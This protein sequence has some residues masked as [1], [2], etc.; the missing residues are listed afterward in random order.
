MIK[1]RKAVAA[2]LETLQYLGKELFS[3]E[4]EFSNEFNLEWPFSKKGKIYFEKLTK[5]R[6]TFALV[7]EAGKEIVGYISITVKH[8]TFR[9]RNKLAVLDNLFIIDDYRGH[10]VGT[11]LLEEANDLLKKRNIERI[12]LFALHSNLKAI[13]FYKKNGFNEFISVLEKDI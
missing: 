5:G 13:E 2:D 12:Q 6:G 4:S 3:Y 1:I 7:A 8:T 11:R 10:G 9:R